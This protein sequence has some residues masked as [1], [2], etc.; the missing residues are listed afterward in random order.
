MIMWCAY[1]QTCMGEREPFDVYELSH[2][3]CDQCEKN[4]VPQDDAAVDA[5]QPVAEYFRK[6]Q[7]AVRKGDLPR[8]STLIDEGQDRGLQP[9]DLAWGVLH[10]L[11]CEVGELWAKGELTV[12]GEHRASTLVMSALDLLFERH[13]EAQAH[14]QAP[15]PFAL[16]CAAEG[17]YHSIGL[18]VLELGLAMKGVDSLVVMPGLPAKEVLALVQS[19]RPPKLGISVSLATQMKSVRELHGLL[20][21]LP[22]AQRPHLVLGGPAFRLG[23]SAPEEW[24]FESSDDLGKLASRWAKEQEALRRL[25]HLEL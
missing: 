16:L 24:G 19:L 10:P 9:F 1:C 21:T 3:V 23:V 13:P 6:L 4:G 15:Q 22:E 18:R 11:L 5:I 7:S 25:A 8:A 12:A 20:Q 14:R 2:G 17:N